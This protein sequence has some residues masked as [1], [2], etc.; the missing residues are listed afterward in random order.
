MCE[1]FLTL[2]PVETYQAIPNAYLWII[3]NGDHITI[4]TE[5][6]Q[7]YFMEIALDFLQG[8]WE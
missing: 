6:H 7:T 2:S 5:K 4:M 1:K 8:N 3:P